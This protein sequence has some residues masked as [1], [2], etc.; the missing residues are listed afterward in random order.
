M[1]DAEIAVH[2]T[3]GLS[4]VFLAQYLSR[5]SEGDT[6]RHGT[7]KV[8]V[9]RAVGF[10]ASN[11]G[12]RTATTETFELIPPR[13]RFLDIADERIIRIFIDLRAP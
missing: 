10:L 1:L 2:F 6:A 8:I 3:L 9:V 4:S 12:T 5:G 7:D 13:S 11:R